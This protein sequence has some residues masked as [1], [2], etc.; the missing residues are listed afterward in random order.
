MR[1]RIR[2]IIFF[3]LAL[4]RQDGDIASQREDEGDNLSCPSK[5]AVKDAIMFVLTMQL[6]HFYLL[7]KSCVVDV[8]LGKIFPITLITNVNDTIVSFD[9]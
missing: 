8:S 6:S 1:A 2:I 7:N 4:T 5:D 9:T 3:Y